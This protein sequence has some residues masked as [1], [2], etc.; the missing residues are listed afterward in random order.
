MLDMQSNNSQLSIARGDIYLAEY[1]FDGTMRTKPVLVVQNDIGNRYSPVVIV[2]PIVPYDGKSQGDLM[3]VVIDENNAEGSN[4]RDSCVMLNV[5]LTLEKSSF[6]EK[7]GALN[8]E[9]M[10]KVEKGLLVS[11]GFKNIGR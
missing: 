1:Y 11:L 6:Q 10:A 3:S 7:I 5:I 8:A 2:V 4:L 9:L